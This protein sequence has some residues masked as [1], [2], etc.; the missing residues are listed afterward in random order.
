MRIQITMDGEEGDLHLDMVR[1]PT[2]PIWDARVSCSEFSEARELTDVQAA[3]T[4][5]LAV[6]GFD[7]LDE[8]LEQQ[9]YGKVGDVWDNLKEAMLRPIP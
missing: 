6:G 2:A 9:L 7:K 5:A 8:A 3:A 1:R 4:V